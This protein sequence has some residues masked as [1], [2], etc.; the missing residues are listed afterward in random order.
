[1][2]GSNVKKIVRDA[3]RN[4]DGGCVKDERDSMFKEIQE[5]MLKDQ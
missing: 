4:K 2:R 3:E 5:D 1:M